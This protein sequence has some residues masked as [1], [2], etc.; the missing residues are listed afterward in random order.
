MNKKNRN[1]IKQHNDGL[2]KSTKDKKVDILKYLRSK[3]REED[4][5]NNIK[6]V[7]LVSKNKKVYNRKDKTWLKSC[8]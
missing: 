4:I 2:K 8:F 3:R 1:L 6:Y 5:R 7:H